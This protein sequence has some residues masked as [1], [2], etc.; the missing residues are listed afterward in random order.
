MHVPAVDDDFGGAGVEVLEL[1]LSRPA[2]V[3]GVAEIAAE[4]RHVEAVRAVADLLVGREGDADESVGDVALLEDLHQGHD[5]RHA[6]FVV[7]AQDRGAVGGDE[8]LALQFKE[9]GEVFGGQDPAGVAQGD[10]AAVV[11]MD[12]RGFHV[13]PGEVGDGVHVG[14]EAQLG[15]VLIPRGGGQGA[16]DVAGVGEAGVL[17][18]QVL[19]LLHQQPG[20]VELPLRGGVLHEVLAA[21]GVYFRVGDEPFV[22]AHGCLLT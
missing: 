9:A 11:V 21:G 7:A 12:Q 15:L 3:Q 1:D 4:A 8:G 6:R 20:E 19:E 22:C 5:L 2:P 10:V 16:V 13:L 17:N 14:D 18:A